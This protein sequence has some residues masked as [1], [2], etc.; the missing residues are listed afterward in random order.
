MAGKQF[1]TADFIKGKGEGQIFLLHGPPGTG[2]TLTA[3]D[4]RSSTSNEAEQDT[5]E[6][7]NALQSTRTDHYCPSLRA[8]WVMNLTSL[9]E[10]C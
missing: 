4:T 5:N 8:T 6:P 10:L 1:F 2:K 7:Q 3:G 9:S